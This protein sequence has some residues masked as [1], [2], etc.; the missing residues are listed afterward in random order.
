[1]FWSEQSRNAI[2]HDRGCR[3]GNNFLLVSK[4]YRRSLL[5]G[6]EIKAIYFTQRLEDANVHQLYSVYISEGVSV[7]KQNL[8]N[9]YPF[10]F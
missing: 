4:H 8:G 2:D 7:K 6:P 3:A 5:I 9:R 10:T 1:M